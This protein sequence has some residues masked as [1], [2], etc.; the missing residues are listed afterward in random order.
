MTAHQIKPRPSSLEKAKR[1]PKYL[2]WLRTEPCVCCGVW[3]RRGKQ[4]EAAHTGQRGRGLGLKAC[5]F[6]AIPLCERCHRTAADSYH[7][8]G[9]ELRWAA[10]HSLDLP[11]IRG[12]LLTKYASQTGV[13]IHPWARRGVYD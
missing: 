10:L 2:K 6:D 4:N 1:S 8:I 5:D 11:R 9:D 13:V 7:A 3:K 12:M